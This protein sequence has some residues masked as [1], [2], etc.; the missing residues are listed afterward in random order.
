MSGMIECLIVE[1]SFN[2][3]LFMAFI[4]DLLE[5]MNPYPA[6]NSVIVMD[7]CSIHKDPQIREMIEARFVFS[8][9]FLT[10]C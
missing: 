9:V 1:G 7:N 5:K 8:F 2:T 4:Q 3:E 10:L 6:P